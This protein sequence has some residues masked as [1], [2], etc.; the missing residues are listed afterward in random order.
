MTTTTRSTELTDPDGTAL[1]ITITD[2][3]VY[4][5]A[6]D[7]DDEV[8]VGPFSAAQLRAGLP[9]VVLTRDLLE[10]LA[11]AVSSPTRAAESWPLLSETERAAHRATA[12]RVATL[13]QGADR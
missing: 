6:T 9:P 3:G 13:L 5:V 1:T 12:H 4:I 11:I 10:E 8:T 2:H 7:G